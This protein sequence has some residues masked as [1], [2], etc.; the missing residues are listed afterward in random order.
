ME[1]LEETIRAEA[2]E[3]RG[4]EL[5]KSIGFEGTVGF[6]E[7]KDFLMIPVMSIEVLALVMM[8]AVLFLLLLME[9]MMTIVVV[10]VVVMMMM[11]MMMIVMAII[12]TAGMTMYSAIS[13]E[14]KG[15]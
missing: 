2:Q 15:S 6:E 4:F 3:R 11:M 5:D 9:M 8:M 1:E 14:E 12:M 7:G 13:G 10:V